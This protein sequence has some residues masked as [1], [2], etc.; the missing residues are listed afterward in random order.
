MVGVDGHL[1]IGAN[2]GFEVGDCISNLDEEMGSAGRRILTMGKFADFWH[3]NDVVEPVAWV[4][5]ELSN[6]HFCFLLKVQN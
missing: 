3:A 2:L 4:A 1:T 6:V 5:G